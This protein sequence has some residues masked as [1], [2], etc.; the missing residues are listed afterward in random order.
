MYKL[1][2]VKLRAQEHAGIYSIETVRVF[3]VTGL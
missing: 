2:K 1:L 3:Q